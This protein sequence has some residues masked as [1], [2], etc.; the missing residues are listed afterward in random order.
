MRYPAAKAPRPPKKTWPT[1]RSPPTRPDGSRSLRPPVQRQ[2]ALPDGRVMRFRNIVSRD[3]AVP[4]ARLI[5]IEHQTPE[6]L[7]QPDLMTHPNGALRL[8]ETVICAADP[9]AT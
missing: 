8:A 2:R 3:A 7:W 5:V 6:L 1:T 9:A 4:E